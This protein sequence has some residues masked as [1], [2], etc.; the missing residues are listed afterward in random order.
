MIRQL[1]VSIRPERDCE[2]SAQIRQ[3][4]HIRAFQVLGFNAILIDHQR[5]SF[6]V[7]LGGDF[8]LM[9]CAPMRDFELSSLRKNNM[10]GV[11]PFC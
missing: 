8:A 7:D 3:P 5:Q 2:F 10:F 1:D 11:H 6:L 9:N 4:S